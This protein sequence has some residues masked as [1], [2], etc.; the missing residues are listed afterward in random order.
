MEKETLVAYT[1][2]DYF[3]DRRDTNYFRRFF[4]SC[5]DCVPAFLILMKNTWEKWKVLSKK[6]GN[7]Q[8]GLFFSILYYVIIVPVGLISSLFNDYFKIKNFPVWEE[9]TDNSSNLKRL[10]E[11]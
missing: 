7:F 11:N 4:A 8:L 9:W 5:P 1:H 6:I 3:F 10:K 2:V